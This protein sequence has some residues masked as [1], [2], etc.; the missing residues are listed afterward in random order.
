VSGLPRPLAPWAAQLAPLTGDLQLAVGEWARRIAAAVG[1]HR[2]DPVETGD[3][4]GFAGL[5]RRGTYDRL[6]LT[7]WILAHEEPEEFTRRAV[8]GEHL[9]LERGRRGHGAPPGLVAL[10]DAGPEQLGTPR[11]AQLAAL[12]VLAARAEASMA[13]F[14]WGVLQAPEVGL[15]RSFDEGEIRRFLGARTR[16]PA[17]PELAAAWAGAEGMRD[18][19]LWLVGGARS[20]GHFPMP[21]ARILVEDV[22]HPSERA[23]RLELRRRGAG[24]REVRLPLPAA[25]VCTRLLRDPFRPAPRAIVRAGERP[26][27]AGDGAVDTSGGILFAPFGRRAALRL[28]GG[29]IV[30]LHVPLS[31]GERAGATRRR[32]I[33][34]G[35]VA[36]GWA[37]RGGKHVTVSVERPSADRAFH[38]LATPWGERWHPD[39][40]PPAEAAVAD[41]V[42]PLLPC[43][44]WP[45]QHPGRYWFLDAKRTLRSTTDGHAQVEETEVAAISVAADLAFLTVKDGQ[46]Q[47]ELRRVG[48]ARRFALGPATG[49]A[50]LQCRAPEQ[51]HHTVGAVETTPGGPWATFSVDWSG[52]RRAPRLNQPLP[53]ATVVGVGGGHWDLPT[54]V[55]LEADRRT[56]NAIGASEIHALHLSDAPVAAAA[57]DPTGMTLAYVTAS[58]E[59]VFYGFGPNAVVLRRRFEVTR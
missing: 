12:V 35:M 3:P 52:V 46:A 14:S 48:E 51:G 7:E 23:L 24:A 41:P 49:P 11:I 19:E 44:L 9:F 55:V 28:Q 8:M 30:D 38:R 6:L 33:V 59:V 42:G 58:G 36:F 37:G 47:V 31:E 21:A 4:E 22:E 27:P 13:G 26:G 39:P 16:V 57:I 32:R 40:Q 2:F 25:P 20:L 56:F 1:P 29:R 10:V 54:L 50:L 34:E 5:T 45:R 17:G 43:Y 53:G 15:H 18:A